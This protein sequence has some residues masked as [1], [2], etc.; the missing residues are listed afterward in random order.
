ML[1]VIKAI[2]LRDNFN[3]VCDRVVSGETV[4]VNRPKTTTSS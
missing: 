4:I 3:D 1:R 2:D